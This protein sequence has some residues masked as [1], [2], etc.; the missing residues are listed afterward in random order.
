MMRRGGYSLASVLLLITVA[1]VVMA[2]A[3]SAYRDFRKADDD[4]L[5]YFGV[6]G[7]LLG[8][9]AGASIAYGRNRKLRRLLAGGPIGLVCGSIAGVMS[10]LPRTAPALALGAV[11]VLLYASAV[12]VFSRRSP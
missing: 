11:V 6:V 4:V 12:R 3:A 7:A 10:C 9:I 8:T 5:V 2:A 1:A